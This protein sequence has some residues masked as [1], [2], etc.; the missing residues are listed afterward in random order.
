MVSSQGWNDERAQSLTCKIHQIDSDMLTT[1]MDLLM[2]KLEDWAVDH[3]KMVD[4]RMMCE[5]YGEMG[6]MGNNC[7]KN[8]EDMNFVGSNNR[9]C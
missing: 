1:K 6:H 2:K 5:V 8:Q 4:A 7:P 9:F 3:F